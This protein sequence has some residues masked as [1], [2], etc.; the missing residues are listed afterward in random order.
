MRFPRPA[1]N[2]QKLRKGPLKARQKFSAID[3]Q[4]GATNR[5]PRRCRLMADLPRRCQGH[6]AVSP[7]ERRPTFPARSCRVRGRPGPAKSADGPVP[8]SPRTARLAPQPGSMP[9]CDQP[10]TGLRP[11]SGQVTDRSPAALPA[12]RTDPRPHSRRPG[13]IPGRP[14][15]GPDRSRPR[16]PRPRPIPGRAPRGP[17]WVR[18]RF[19]RGFRRGFAARSPSGF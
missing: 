15:G 12:A 11:G 19:E 4:C 18:G 3:F 13:P 17:D 5:P 2:C 9:V 7:I 14:P 8:P 16:S 6:Y 10:T 1:I